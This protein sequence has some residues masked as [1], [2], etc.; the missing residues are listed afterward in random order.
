MAPP[1]LAELEPDPEAEIWLFRHGE[2]EWSRTGRH[3]GCTDLPLRAAGEI[4]EEV[5]G[6]LVWT[7]GVPG[8]ET[9]EQ[10]GCRARRVIDQAVQAPGDVALFAHGHVLRILAACWIGL[11][12]R[13]GRLLALDTASSGLLGHESGSRVIR[14]WNVPPGAP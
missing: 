4:R 2:T 10:V 8:G 9:A 7:D 6:W 11:S 14:A 12:P 3:R 5:P 1:P 13:E